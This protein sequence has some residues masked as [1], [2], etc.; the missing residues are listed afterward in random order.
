VLSCYRAEK[1][2]I[3]SDIY[4]ETEDDERCHDYG[5]IRIGCLCVKCMQCKWKDDARTEWQDTREAAEEQW[6]EMQT[7]IQQG[8][9][10]L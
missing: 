3:P 6:E 10:P 5:R 8:D 2:G 7:E 4:D 1:A 9:L